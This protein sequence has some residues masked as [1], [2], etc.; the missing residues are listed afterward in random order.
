MKAAYGASFHSNSLLHGTS[1]PVVV[2]DDNDHV[3]VD[4]KQLTDMKIPFAWGRSGRVG[5]A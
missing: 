3:I 5:R 1:I 2:I 4:L